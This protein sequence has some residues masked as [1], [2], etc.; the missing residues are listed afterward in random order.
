MIRS[1]YSGISGLRN[2]Q[3]AM[4]VTS[5]NIANVNT[6]G[7]KSSRVTFKESMS[8]LLKGASRPPGERGGTNPMQVGL[9]MGVGSIDTMVT[10][11]ALKSTGQ[12]TDL[13]VDGRSYF[14]FSDGENTFY[15]RNGALQLDGNGYLV[16]P[17]NGY[18]LQGLTADV[19]GNIPPHAVTG[20]IQ[21]PYGEKAPALATEVIEFSC[22]LSSD[23]AGLGTVLHTARFLTT[24]HST[25]TTQS[26][27]A[28][29]NPTDLMTNLFDDKGNDLGIKIGDI[30]EI[31]NSGVTEEL[32]ILA[33]TTLTDLLGAIDT[34]T[35]G[36]SQ[37]LADGSVDTGAAVGAAGM[38]IKNT[39]RPTSDA[40]VKN[41]FNFPAGGNTNSKPILTATIQ[42]DLLAN[43]LDA[44]GK[45]L[46]FEDGDEIN[47][48]GNIGDN[49]VDNTQNITTYAAATSTMDNLIDSIRVQLN[50]PEKVKNGSGIEVDSLSINMGGATGDNRSPIGSILIRGQS[51]EAFSLNAVSVNATNSNNT[52]IAPS[53]FISNMVLTEVQSARNTLVHSTSI[54]VYDESGAAHTVT[55]TYT[56]TDTPGEWL[57]EASM[58]GDEQIIDGNTGTIKFGLDGSPAAMSY[59][60]SATDFRFNPMNGSNDVALKLSMGKSGSFTGVTQFDSP[61]TT[62][63]KEQDGYGM[64]T[65]SEIS[66]NED[67]SINGSY[68]N[69]VSKKIGTILLAEFTNPGGLLRAGDSMFSKSNNSGEGVLHQATKGT[70]SKIK[71]GALEMSNVELADEF[72]DLITIQRGYSANAKVITT[73]DQLLQELV[74]LVR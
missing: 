26:G 10:Q 57:W 74:Q 39:T 42:E 55:T 61:T 6:T 45:P 60:N 38:T 35:G 27:T 4:D 34:A 58:T 37:I 49:S 66:I 53:A 16:S 73:S 28:T 43:V 1:L 48:S 47:V 67:G 32:E 13:A 22:N 36:A 40:F 17:N 5:H 3:V 63:A 72:T 71:P 52:S 68:S 62:A 64:G 23:S 14:A 15:S 65:L 7:Y 54:E 12:I 9:G 25:P 18:K 19:N 30:L 69:G 70:T 56:R 41:L 31:N 8:Q 33:G 2:H 11:G 29:P 51:Q 24:A 50:L 21:I 44:N 20:P 46:G 59:D